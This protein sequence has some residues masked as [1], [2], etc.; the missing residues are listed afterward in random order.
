M[1][2][3]RE[4]V[5][6]AASIGNRLRPGCVMISCPAARARLVSTTIDWVAVYCEPEYLSW[7]PPSRATAKASNLMIRLLG[8]SI[9]RLGIDNPP[10]HAMSD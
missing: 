8:G 4:T 10:F 1:P 2:R 5:R 9:R 7:P 3:R 6:P